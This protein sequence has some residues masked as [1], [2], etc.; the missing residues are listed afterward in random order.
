MRS[1]LLLE[2]DVKK[3]MFVAKTVSEDR[4]SVRYSAIDFDT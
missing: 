1:S 2:I 4:S 3:S